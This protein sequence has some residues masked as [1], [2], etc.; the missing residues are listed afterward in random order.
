V[1]LDGT[2]LKDRIHQEDTSLRTL[3]G[4]LVE[5]AE[6]LA[7]AHRAGMPAGT[8]PCM[9]PEQ[10]RGKPP[11]HRSDIFAFGAILYEAC[12]RRQPFESDSDLDVR[13]RILH[14]QP[15]AIDQLNPNVPAEV[16]RMV[17]RCMAKDPD[18][19]Y[20]SMKDVAVE[21]RDIVREFDHL[22]ASRISQSVTQPMEILGSRRRRI[23]IA[24]AVIAFAAITFGAMRWLRVDAGALPT[25]ASDARLS[26]QQA[27]TV[28][29]AR[30]GA[31][32][33]V[34]R[35]GAETPGK[36]HDVAIIDAPGAAPRFLTTDG[37]S[38][39]AA[40]SADGRTVV[41][42][43]G[44]H[45]FAVNADGSGRRQVTAGAGE[46]APR[47]SGDGRTLLYVTGT[48]LWT[49]PVEGSASRRI[50]DRLFG[51]SAAISEDGRR[52]VYQEAAGG[53]TVRLKIVPIAGGPPLLDVPGGFAEPFRFHPDG[54]S[55]S[56]VRLQR[57]VSNI[58]TMRLGGG[59][60][61][62]VTRFDRG[63][64]LDYDWLPGGK[65]VV[66]R[67]HL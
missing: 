46:L 41:Y 62:Q 48:T 29:A 66:S 19:R 2:T 40:I 1:H 56:F 22:S 18:K 14:V 52:V 58:W 60:P 30:T 65:L 39:D 37:V 45:V 36:K 17:R 20:H 42:V 21:L 47:V 15:P 28:S 11:D 61:V 49:K 59:E 34:L 35:S 4:W 64:I 5:V 43:S 23:V 7:E 16:R 27:V 10:V 12:T 54:A 9:S 25:T 31:V 55:L 38:A 8:L 53:S 26:N 67:T 13:H 3:L 33:S 24:A 6:G 51:R 44:A 57:G 32:V 50:T 63:T